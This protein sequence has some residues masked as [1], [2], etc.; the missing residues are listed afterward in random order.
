MS[1]AGLK[2]V[3]VYHNLSPAELYEKASRKPRDQPSRECR[4]RAPGCVFSGVRCK[5]RLAHHRSSTR[6]STLSSHPRTRAG[7]P[8]RAQQPY[9]GGRRAGH[10][11][12]RQ[13]GPQVSLACLLAACSRLCGRVGIHADS[14]AARTAAAAVV[15]L[16]RWQSSHCRCG[17]RSVVVGLLTCAHTRRKKPAVLTSLLPSFPPLLP[18]PSLQPQGQAHCAGAIQ[19]GGCVV[20]RGLTQL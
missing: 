15:P 13:D 10:H 7:A 1:D 3:V 8:V 9:R 11:F 14:C 18:M 2:P 16:R 5:A 6:S 19:R 17:L 20:G 12:G 4:E